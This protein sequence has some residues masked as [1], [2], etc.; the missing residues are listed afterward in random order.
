MRIRGLYVIADTSILQDAVLETK[1]RQ[2]LSGGA[3][4]I[5]YRD[6]SED[7]NKRL[8]QAK[9]L[10]GLCAE[11]D[12]CFIVNDDP[13]LARQV[14]AAGVHIGDN[15]ATIEAARRVV[16]ESMIIG[17]SCYN[18]IE[19]ARDAE[20]RGAQY[21]AF[22]SFFPSTVKPNAVRSTSRL[23][24]QARKELSIPIVVIGGITYE[25]GAGLIEAGAD[26]LA[27]ISAVFD[28]SDVSLACKRLS[29]LFSS[30]GSL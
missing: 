18:R 19:L 1:A 22:G 4:F 24:R 9:L 27:V 12:K 20:R 28:Q 11:F 23:L 3:E 30:S 15:D 5:Q 26:A 21:V 14:G 17:V 16:G 7:H 2:A 10:Q 8:R 29:G 25:N 13:E 6:K